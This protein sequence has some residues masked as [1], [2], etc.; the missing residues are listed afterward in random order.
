MRRKTSLFLLIIMMCVLTACNQRGQ[1]AISLE[2]SET[3]DANQE[4]ITTTI[5]VHV[6]GAVVNEGVYELPSGS[7][8]YEALEKAGG[9]LPNAATTEINQAEL[10]DDGMKLYVPT[11]EEIEKLQLSGNAKININRATKEE[12]MTL[13]GIGAAKAESIIQ[14]RKTNG[15][16]R[17]TK[18]LMQI[19]GI[20]ESLYEQIKDLIQVYIRG[21]HLWVKKYWL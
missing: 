19:S 17:S 10:L 6:C 14:Y 18:D 15:S 21:I 1:E 8:V 2:Y 13:P 7:R 20:K 11:I 5:F 9:L 16:F 12:L 3:E 4:E